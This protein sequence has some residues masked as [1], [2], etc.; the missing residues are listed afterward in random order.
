M[1]STFS[2]AQLHEI[3]DRVWDSAD[4]LPLKLRGGR[5]PNT[6]E[7]DSEWCCAG[8]RVIVGYVIPFIAGILLFP[9][10]PGDMSFASVACPGEVFPGRYH[11][12]L[13]STGLK[14][15][16]ERTIR[17]IP[18]SS[19]GIHNASLGDTLP[20]CGSGG[21]WGVVGTA[22]IIDGMI[23]REEVDQFSAALL[24]KLKYHGRSHPIVLHQ[25]DPATPPN[26][27][28]EKEGQKGASLPAR[29][30]IAPCPP[31]FIQ[32]FPALPISPTE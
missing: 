30:A 24:S 26:S 9:S 19:N 14:G 5:F 16:V 3:R 6:T 27:P 1:V 8:N 18:S 22:C 12:V 20:K 13:Y 11:T 7:A 23:G 31:W 17:A 15:P 32:S 2:V 4:V 29:E 25:E 28:G 10:E 21:G